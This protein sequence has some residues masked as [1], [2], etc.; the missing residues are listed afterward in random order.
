MSAKPQNPLAP[1]KA[2]KGEAY[3]NAKQLEHFRLV[4]NEIKSEVEGEI[5][6]VLAKNGEPVE[7]GQPLFLIKP[8]R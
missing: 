7:F 2:K 3:M 5:V 6:E 8:S 1:Y 4:M